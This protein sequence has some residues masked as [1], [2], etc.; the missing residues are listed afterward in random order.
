MDDATFK[1]A[2][3][4]EL[5]S[6]RSICEEFEKKAG[7]RADRGSDLAV[8]EDRFPD[9]WATSL[10]HRG[11]T[12]ACEC[13]EAAGALMLNGVWS[14]PQYALLRAAYESAGAT[15][16]LLLPEETDTR[17]ARLIYQHRESWKY[18]SKAYSGTPLDDDGEHE[19]RQQWATDA[20]ARL[21]IDLSQGNPRGYEKLIQSIDDLPRRPE[22]LLTAW[23]LCSGVSHAKTWAMS[24]VIV[25]VESTELHEHARLVAYEPNLDVFLTMLRTARRAVQYA[26]VLYQIRT[27]TRPHSMV[28]ELVENTTVDGGSAN[29]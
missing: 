23:Q 29:S 6:V 3:Y 25:Q 5:E 28:L 11:L 18:S 27:T 17:L 22:S 4:T 21:Q 13:I 24:E 16:W 20:A 15:V 2:I 7:Q 8:D 1:R 9:I 10:A 14:Y 26:G 19:A 12:H